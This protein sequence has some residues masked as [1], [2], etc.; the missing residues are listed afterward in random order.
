MLVTPEEVRQITQD[1]L[2]R[3]EFAQR[4]TLTQLLMDRVLGWL[5][6]LARWAARNPTL[7]PLLTYGLTAILVLLIGH[8]VYTVVRE[9]IS[10]RK[11]D[12]RS[13]FRRGCAG[14][15]WEDRD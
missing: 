2:S 7:A 1:V 6:D 8:I 9:F 3:P 14:V 12:G 5:D 4:L 10:L 15:C 11:T 13:G